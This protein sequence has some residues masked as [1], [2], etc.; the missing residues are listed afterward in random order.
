MSEQKAI[1]H[2]FQLTVPVVMAHPHLDK[3]QA[4]KRKGK[5]AGEPKFGASFVLDPN[6]PDF[7]NLKAEVAKAIK[8]KWPGRELKGFKV[9]WTAGDRLIEKYVAKKKA[10]G[11]EDDGKAD[12]QK[13]MQVVKGASK[14]RPKLAVVENG[15][16]IDVTDENMALHK[17]KFYFGVQAL[18][19]FNLVAYDKIN[20]DAQDGVTAYL[21]MVVSL[22]KGER[23]TGGPTAAE[24]FKGVVGGLSAEDPTGGEAV[25]DHDDFG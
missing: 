2:S 5:D 8:A 22:N 24:T 7:A 19:R 23:L 3:P 1:N 20:D 9:P 15:E 10:E 25:S 13:G 12:F 16:L 21:D 4:F 14:Y 18:A 6:G 11:K 17:G